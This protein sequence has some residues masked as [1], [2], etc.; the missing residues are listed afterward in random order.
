MNAQ[1]TPIVACLV[2]TVTHT[3]DGPIYRNEMW[4]CTRDTKFIG[5]QM[6]DR[7]GNAAEVKR[8]FTENEHGQ[9]VEF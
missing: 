9:L 7:F 5:S 6:V 1:N 2:E 8:Q 4:F 3:E